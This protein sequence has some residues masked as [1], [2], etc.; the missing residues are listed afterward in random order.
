MN[1][2]NLQINQDITDGDEIVALGVELVSVDDF[3]PEDEKA[4]EDL[5]AEKQLFKAAQAKGHFSPVLGM[6]QIKGACDGRLYAGLE[7]QEDGKRVVRLKQLQSDGTYTPCF[8][9]EQ[10]SLVISARHAKNID[11]ATKT[12]K[13]MLN[14]FI[15]EFT[16]Q[17]YNVTNISDIYDVDDILNAVIRALPNLPI[18]VSKNSMM[19]A[20]EF[21]IRLVDMIYELPFVVSDSHK[22]HFVLDE[23]A[24]D[25]LAESMEMSKKQLLGYLREFGFLYL[26][27]SSLE[28]KTRVR[29]RL[30]CLTWSY[31]IKRLSYLDESDADLE[32]REHVK[33]EDD[34]EI[35]Y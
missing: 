23:K 9:I 8:T 3:T 1:N 2:K 21:Y 4:V 6:A 28:Y 13:A 33:L 20:R 5:E 17:Y 18:V 11:T 29:D 27:Q 24:L 26:T 19:D 25:E 12:V 7:I 30:G 35:E 15:R 34:S 22:S 14:K 31:C 16:S 10:A 32:S